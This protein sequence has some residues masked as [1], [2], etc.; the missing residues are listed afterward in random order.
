MVGVNHFFK[1]FRTFE[2]VGIFLK[3][4]HI[5][6]IVYSNTFHMVYNILGHHSTN[7]TTAKTI[8]EQVSFH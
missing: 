2:N 5:H 6:C 1:I 3:L 7:S 4:Q 8:G